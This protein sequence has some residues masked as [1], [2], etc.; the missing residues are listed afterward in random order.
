ML[1]SDPYEIDKF[2]MDRVLDFSEREIVHD[3]T[4]KLLE[5]YVKVLSKHL[6]LTFRDTYHL[7]REMGY[8]S[9]STFLDTVIRLNKNEKITNI[10]LSK[11]MHPLNVESQFFLNEK[12]LEGGMW[13]S[14]VMRCRLSNV[15]L[16]TFGIPPLFVEEQDEPRQIKL[17]D[18]DLLL[19]KKGRSWYVHYNLTCRI[20]SSVLQ[21][22]KA[23]RRRIYKKFRKN[24]VRIGYI[25]LDYKSMEQLPD[26]QWVDLGIDLA[27]YVSVDSYE[28]RSNLYR[29]IQVEFVRMAK[30]I[31]GWANIIGRTDIPKS[32]LESMLAFIVLKSESLLCDKNRLHAAVDYCRDFI[33]NLQLS[34][35]FG[36][37]NWFRFESA[38][39]ATAGRSL[40]LPVIE[41]QSGGCVLDRLGNGFDRGGVDDGR[42]YVDHMLYWGGEGV[43]ANS[44]SLSK[45]LRVPYPFL[46]DKLD[47]YKKIN[48]NKHLNVIYTPLAMSALYSTENWLSIS[49]YDMREVRDHVASAFSLLDHMVERGR[50][51]LYVKIKGFSYRMF[52]NKEFML[53]P[54]LDLKNISIEYIGDGDAFQYFKYMDVHVS[55][56]NSTTFVYSMVFNIPT[57]IIW[58]PVFK[59]KE[60][61]TSLFNSLSE[62]GVICTDV[63]CFASNF[64]KISDYNYWSS[65]EVQDVR[66]EFCDRFGYTSSD[67]SSEINAAL[68]NASNQ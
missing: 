19:S 58:S 35:L 42:F 5:V 48:K 21:Y 25:A 37:G 10:S 57:I 41:F 51:N 68:L 4:I 8:H 63:K 30:E 24:L 44:D 14:R 39:I 33:R 28:D 52:K 15:I 40:Q 47:S 22:I 17:D 55:C 67:W 27:D 60:E 1:V 6:D 7:S 11:D 9:V 43:S 46:Y 2:F 53:I 62:I 64:S 50:L 65:S 23:Y 38:V 18:L 3:F 45:Y 20:P 34:A 26:V 12:A 66:K 56:S 49:T 32:F 16:K 54:E 36:Q 29:S 61:Y 59:V 31:P 13:G